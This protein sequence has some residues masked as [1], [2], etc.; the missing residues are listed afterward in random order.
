MSAE[1]K[2]GLLVIFF[3][4][5]AIATGLYLTDVLGRMSS[6]EITVQFEDVQ[7]LETGAQVRL[8]GVFIGR[9][10]D[11]KLSPH[12]NFPNR[13]AAVI[14]QIHRDVLLYDTDTFE[15]KQGA[16]VGDKYLEITHAPKSKPRKRLHSGAVVAGAGATSAGIIMDETRA[17]IATA[18][19]TVDSVRAVAGDE[20]TQRNMREIIANL[21]R[22]T[23]RA[24]IIT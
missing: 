20:E 24:V 1:A 15:I 22:A 8:G 2:V 12:P 11:V 9:V 21:N 6:Q 7:G 16:V 18:R 3:A 17:L 14:A 4:I 13:P 23:A 10:A 5:L 19:A